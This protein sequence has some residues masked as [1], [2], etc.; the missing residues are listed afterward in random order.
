MSTRALL[1]S[2]LSSDGDNDGERGA[3][4]QQQHHADLSI[5]LWRARKRRVIALEPD[6]SDDLWG[7]HADAAARSGSGSEAVEPLPAPQLVSDEVTL[8]HDIAFGHSHRPFPAPSAASAASASSCES[9]PTSSLSARWHFQSLLPWPVLHAFGESLLCRILFMSFLV[10]FVVLVV[11]LEFAHPLLLFVCVA[12]VLLW[13]LI[14]AAMADKNIVRQAIM[15]FEWWYLLVHILSFTVF[16]SWSTVKESPLLTAEYVCTFLPLALAA[17]FTD[18]LT[19]RVSLRIRIAYLFLGELVLAHMFITDL[20]GAPLF[21]PR[22]FCLV[23]C[24]DTRKWISFSCSQIVVLLWQVPRQNH[25]E[26]TARQALPGVAGI[27]LQCEGH[28]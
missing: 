26:R 11:G 10:M 16:A 8:E 15:S 3:R 4:Q 19:P 22:P 21:Q 18:A 7:D 17:S 2:S 20:A 13:S 9:A 5:G 1:S 24:T 6:L 28:R 12:M 27:S 14:A 25:S 23:Y